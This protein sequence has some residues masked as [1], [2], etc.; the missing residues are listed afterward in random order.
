MKTVLAFAGGFALALFAPGPHAHA[1]AWPLPPGEGQAILKFD[2]Q[3]PFGIY[4]DAGALGPVDVG[5]GDSAV[6]L[7]VE[8][9]L[10]D[11]FT[12]QGKWEARRKADDFVDYEGSGP[13]EIGLRG[14]LARG[15]RGVAA[16]YFGF[17]SDGAEVDAEARILLG[18]ADAPR[19]WRGRLPGGFAEI[20]AARIFRT[21]RPDE[22]RLDATLGV[23]L[24]RRW[25]VAAQSFA[26]AVDGG[27][28]WI[29]GEFSVTRGQG[30]WRVQAGWRRTLAGHDVRASEGPVLALWRRF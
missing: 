4:D 12:L 5:G 29:V 6:S 22:S 2:R 11:R 18:R 21:S 10:N 3:T 16:G 14:V 7:F 13:T 8:Y 23:D 26:G 17:I 28:Q 15:R 25:S 9:G 19:T 27:A 24:S 30:D 1:G 20:Q